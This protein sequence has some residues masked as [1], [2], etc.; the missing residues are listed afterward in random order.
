MSH[1]HIAIFVVLLAAVFADGTLALG[2][3]YE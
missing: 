3:L 1:R 2:R